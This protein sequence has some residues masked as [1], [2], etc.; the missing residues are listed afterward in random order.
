VCFAYF[1][2]FYSPRSGTISAPFSAPFIPQVPA[3]QALTQK[4][5]PLIPSPG[6]IPAASQFETENLKP[7][8]LKLETPTS[9]FSLS[10][11]PLHNCNPKH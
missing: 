11:Q 9:A 10:P 1:V 2:V 5:V 7:E 6:F 4:A 8:N 3:N